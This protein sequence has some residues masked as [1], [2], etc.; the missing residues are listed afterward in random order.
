MTTLDIKNRTNESNPFEK[1]FTEDDLSFSWEDL[2]D[3]FVEYLPTYECYQ[4][5]TYDVVSAPGYSLLCDNDEIR[6]SYMDYLIYMSSVLNNGWFTKE[7]WNN[8][9]SFKGLSNLFT[10]GT[11]FRSL[12]RI[13]MYQFQFQLMKKIMGDFMEDSLRSY[14]ERLDSSKKLKPI[15]ELDFSTIDFIKEN[16][17]FDVERPEFNALLDMGKNELTQCI[18]VFMGEKGETLPTQEMLRKQSQT[19]QLLEKLFS[20]IKKKNPDKT[21][22]EVRLMVLQKFEKIRGLV[23]TGGQY[24]LWYFNSKW[25]TN[26]LLPKY[27]KYI[28]SINDKL[29]ELN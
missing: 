13:G 2:M 6:L 14:F 19:F 22:D 29:Y 27:K 1:L 3:K 7:W 15:S 5:F 25:K 11:R 17:I 21:S 23:G 24:I 10:Q 8:N 26:P 20:L 4:C 16:Q 9:P 28:K 12:V 18:K